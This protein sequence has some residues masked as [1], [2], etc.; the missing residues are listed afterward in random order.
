MEEKLDNLCENFDKMDDNDK[1]ELLS[2]GENYLK[3]IEKFEDGNI[4]TV[5]DKE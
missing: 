2:I 1:N 5:E 4:K 3:N